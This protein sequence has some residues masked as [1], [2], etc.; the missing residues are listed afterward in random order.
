M[1]RNSTR[2][3]SRKIH[4]ATAVAI[5]TL[6]IV[7]LAP[8]STTFAKTPVV[9]DVITDDYAL[10]YGVLDTDTYTLYPYETDTSLIIG[11]SKYGEFINDLYNVGLEYE[12]KVDPFAPPAGRDVGT[13]PKRMWIQGWLINITYTHTT[14]GRRNVWACALF[15]DTKAYGGTWIRVDFHG[16]WSETYGYEDPRDPGYIIGN[17]AAGPENYGGRKTNGTAVTEPIE[18]LYNGPR[19]FVA[20]LVTTIYDHPLYED[21]S[22][23]ADIPLVKVIFTIIFNKVKKQIIV[24][25]DIKSILTEK[26]GTKMKIQFSDRGQVDLGNEAVGYHSYFHFYTAGTKDPEDDMAEGQT[27]VYNS[28][29]TMC[30]TEAPEA[31]GEG[32]LGSSLT[33]AGPFPQDVDAT[34]DVAQAINPDIEVV[35]WAAFWPSL[36]DWSIDGWP[37][38]WKSMMAYDPHYIDA[39]GYVNPELPREPKIPFYIGEWDFYLWAKEYFDPENPSA[40]PIQFRGVTIYGVAD[41]HDGD[42]VHYGTDNTIDTEVSYQLDEVFN[43]IDLNDAVHKKTR[44]HVVF[45]KGPEITLPHKVD[46]GVV[47]VEDSEWDDYCVFAERVIDLTEGEVEAREGCNWKGQD[48]YTITVNATTGEVTISDLDE[49]HKYMILY[50]T[51]PGTGRYEWIAI[52]RDSKAIDSAGAAMVSEAFDSL[53]DIPVQLSGFDMYDR[54]WAPYAPYLMARF[55]VTTGDPRDDWYYWNLGVANDWRTALKD[56][57]CGKIPIA[58]SNIIA[59]AGPWANLV[60]EYFNEFLPVIHRGLFYHRASGYIGADDMMAL[61]CWAKNTFTSG[62]AVIAVY[63]D[64][65]GTVGFIVW[66]WD[67]QDTYE[68]C[69]WLWEGGIEQLQDAPDGLVAIVLKFDYT[70]HPTKVTVEECLGTFSECL[71]MHGEEEKGGIHDP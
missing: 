3:V 12:G 43:P 1:S 37:I 59:V 30:K 22:T 57:W 60:T 10:I 69:K 34:F 63:K 54:I 19:L 49:D 64:L 2:H 65:N 67:G 45:D 52:G 8:Y 56:N 31:E 13:I 33:A 11:F 5:L 35:W 26:E 71:W 7:S 44:R 42:D 39:A 23:A 4:A 16:D 18:V 27:T 28:I 29:W 61:T 9:D 38:W 47:V 6:I 51:A 62:T 53:K 32:Y 58:S 55:A 15:A 17:Y 14:L 46:E 21:D 40:Y 20:K 36:S 24:L 25:K 68:A 41:L 70:K 66:G 50:S 48:T